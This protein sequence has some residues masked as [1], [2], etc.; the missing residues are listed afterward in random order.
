[1]TICITYILTN[2][3]YLRAYRNIYAAKDPFRLCAALQNFSGDYPAI[4]ILVERYIPEVEMK[5]I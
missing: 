3:L 4:Y 2:I 5:T 1:M